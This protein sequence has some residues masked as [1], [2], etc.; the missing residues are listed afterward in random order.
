MFTLAVNAQKG[1][2]GKSTISQHIAVLAEQAGWATAIIDFD[3]QGSSLS[4]ARRRKERGVEDPP[5]GHVGDRLPEALRAAE[6]DGFDLVILDTP[7]NVEAPVLAASQAADLILLLVCPSPKDMDALG[8]TARLV[9]KLGK[10]S[11]LLLN[12][13]R[14]ASINQDVV[15][16]LG[17]QFGLAVCPMTISDRRA[18]M[19]ADM[20]GS[21]LNELKSKS[22]TVKK[23][24][25]EFTALW[26][27]LK[28]QLEG[29]KHGKVKEKRYA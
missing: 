14:G 8:A 3:P 16:M 29:T 6:D 22:P 19:D 24:Q 28:K 13:G 7:P 20:D 21:T 18:I 26:K 2:V 1:G 27:W 4:W 5:V 17:E 11:F 9:E 25:A 23:G 15:H 10:P 12:K